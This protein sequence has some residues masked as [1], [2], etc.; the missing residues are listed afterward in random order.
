L[1]HR[2]GL[3]KAKA[4]ERTK[5]RWR[6]RHEIPTEQDKK[7]ANFISLV[8]DYLTKLREESF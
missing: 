3:P 7:R 5:Y 2:N 8:K 6:L 1:S 4:S